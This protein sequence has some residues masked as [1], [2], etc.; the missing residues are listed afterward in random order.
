VFSNYRLLYDDIYL[1]EVIIDVKNYSNSFLYWNGKS[2]L[3]ELPRF[4]L[5]RKSIYVRMV[6]AKSKILIDIQV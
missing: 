1:E 3:L 5:Y 4:K 2:Y 6:S